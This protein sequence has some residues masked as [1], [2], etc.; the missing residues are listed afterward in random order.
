[1]KKEIKYKACKGELHNGQLVPLKEFVKHRN[2]ADG[3][4]NICKKCN[5][6]K[7]NIAPKNKILEELEKVNDKLDLLINK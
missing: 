7:Y 1:M 6:L 2:Y 3:Y 5:N 4:A